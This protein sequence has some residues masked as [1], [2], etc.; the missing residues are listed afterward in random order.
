[1]SCSVENC[2][3]EALFFC[4]CESDFKMLCEVHSDFHLNEFT[5][6]KIKLIYTPVCGQEKKSIISTILN[7]LKSLNQLKFRLE[8]ISK[9]LITTINMS[10][11]RAL[12][13]IL[14]SQAILLSRIS[15]ISNS[16]ILKTL[17]Y[18]NF[19]DH[20]DLIFKINPDHLDYINLILEIDSFYTKDFLSS[21]EK[22]NKKSEGLHNAFSLFNNSSGTLYNLNPITEELEYSDLKPEKTMGGSA[23]SCLL[24][25]KKV[26]YYGGQFSV[27]TWP[28]EFCSI[29][30]PE[31]KKVE[32]KRKGPK[33]M[34]NIG[35][36]AYLDGKV[37][38][39]GGS[40]KCRIVCNNAFE[41]N[42]EGDSW[43]S[44]CDL[45]I[46][47]EKNCALA[48]FGGVAVTGQRIGGYLY[49][50]E[51]D[52]YVEKMQKSEGG[53][54]L[55]DCGR[56]L[57]VLANGGVCVW[58]EDGKVESVNGPSGVSSE[59]YMKS[60][61]IIHSNWIYFLLSDKNLYRMHHR[62]YV[63]EKLKKYDVLFG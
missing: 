1:M 26:F 34:Y 28:S 46:G 41:Y 44:I 40:G 61:P 37:Y 33:R 7:E 54:V 59:L 15:K 49:D 35:T 20:E 31:M 45:P 21:I 30:D 10:L 48:A 18:E 50:I 53:K 39:F 3:L 9:V 58:S 14:N 51:K 5:D 57:V 2:S 11:S 42:I 63:V 4:N 6:H 55:L 25:N 38:M 8:Q 56:N 60:Y 52:V 32:F 62:T 43:K 23:G 24:P 13:P 19:I 47:S 17:E 12:T 22:L 27:M 29:I 36:C 16:S